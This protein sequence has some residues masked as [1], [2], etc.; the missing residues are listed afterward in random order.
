MAKYLVAL[1]NSHSADLATTR[2]AR[3]PSSR[4]KRLHLLYI[5]NDVLYQACL[6]NQDPSLATNLEP[7]L[8]SL[9][10][11]AAAFPDSPKHTKK[12]LDL[13]DIWEQ[14]KYYQASTIEKFRQSVRDGPKNRDSATPGQGSTTGAIHSHT[15]PSRDAPFVMPTMHGDATLPWHDLPAAN[16][17]PVME[18]NSTRPMNPEMIRPLRFASGP[19]DKQLIKAVQD[20]LTDVDRIY[21]K[22]CVNRDDRTE[23]I[24]QMGQRVTVDEITG[25]VAGG[26]TYYGWSRSFCHKMKLRR[27]KK[28]TSSRE[29]RSRSMAHTSSR[30]LSRSRS[31]SRGA[32][33]PA[34]KRRRLSTSPDSQRGRTRSRSRSRSYGRAR[35]YSRDRPRHGSYDSSTSRSPSRSRERSSSSAVRQRPYGRSPNPPNSGPRPLSN[36]PFPQPPMLMQPGFP[37]APPNHGHFPVPPPPPPNYQGPWPPP[38][39]LPPAGGMPPNWMPPMPN[40]GGGWPVPPPPPPPQQQGGG[41]GGYQQYGRGGRGE[42]HGQGYRG[43]GGGGGWTRGRGW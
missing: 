5:V 2:S 36:P 15:K 19:V 9:F 37:P 30:S 18:P 14:N 20:L 42:Y 33:R 13:L 34:F 29:G 10:Q 39:P 21:S 41:G 6:R 8:P 11:S 40:L 26:E 35:E 32:S 16:W 24:D 27:A 7:A 1:A 43:G 28:A 31:P 38:P 3:E 17:L 23:S 4:R 12:L 25:E 22:E